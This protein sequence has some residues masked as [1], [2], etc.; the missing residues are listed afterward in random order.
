MQRVSS[1]KWRGLAAVAAASLIATASSDTRAQFPDASGLSPEAIRQI[2]AILAEKSRRTPPQQKISS[3]LLDAGRVSAGGPAT[4]AAARSA[5]VPGADGRVD[6][7]IYADVTPGVLARIADAGGSVSDGPDSSPVRARLPVSALEE[8]AA[9][10]EVRFIQSAS[11]GGAGGEAGAVDVSPLKV[12]TSAGD[13]AHRATFARLFYGV[14]GAGVG[15]GVLANG[16]DTLASRQASGDLPAVT[17]LGGQQGSGGRGTAML[18]IVHDLAPA[19]NLFFATSSGGQAQMAANIQ[20]LCSAGARV[21]VGDASYEDEPVFQDGVVA[22]AI[23][24]VTANGCL[25][26]ASAGD[27]GN[28]T[29]GT[30]GI[31]EGDFVPSTPLGSNGTT[32]NFGGVNYNIIAADQSHLFT[33]QWSDPWGASSNDYDLFLLNAS[34]TQVLTSSTDVQNGTQNPYESISTP[35]IE[36][37]NR[38]VIVRFSGATRYLHLNAHRGRLTISTPGRIAGHA[39]AKNAMTVGAVDVAVAHGG[40]FPSGPAVPVTPYS[41]DGPRRLFYHPDGAAITPGDLS[42]TGGELVPKPDFA[43]GDCVS[44]S[45]PGH[46]PFCGTAAAAAHAAAI[47]ALMLE[48]DPSLTR[49]TLGAAISARAL[50]IAAAG[51]DRDAGAGIVDAL[52]AVGRTHPAFVDPTL[53]P[54]ATPV[55]AVHVSQLRT[56]VNALRVRCG[57]PAVTF[58]DATLTPGATVM[59]AAHI[60]ELR[61]ALNDAYAACG[62]PLPVYSDSPIAPGTTP[63]RAAHIN[64]L[65]A[66]IVGLE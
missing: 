27:F 15:V 1:W 13:A 50:D 3:D 42:S 10:E 36:T 46:S 34:G 45:T 55:K 41:A 25:Y 39:G 20:A 48:I 32:H 23:N 5:V 62:S 52:G 61:S 40:A 30:S 9:L 24:A 54:R 37:N 43:A 59:K 29:S 44:T 57:L 51:P 64:E 7:E 47:A 31:W 26:F 22:Q 21:I 28:Q 2:E 53:V 65:R 58:T 12:D 19:A 4:T 33:L 60:A 56:R 8:I 35:F 6:V 63:V 16:V 11:A 18:E 14:T 17:V 66:A 49:A 38:L